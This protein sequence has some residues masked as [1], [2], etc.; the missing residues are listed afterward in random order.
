MTISQSE[1]QYIADLVLNETA[2]VLDADK[3]YLVEARLSLLVHETGQEN[4]S[5]LIAMARIPDN[6]L[7]REHIIDAMTTN[8]TSFFR[9]T[10]PFSDL[11]D[12]IM[13]DLIKARSDTR[14]INI[15]C[16]ASSSGQEPYSIAMTLHSNFKILKD[17]KLNITASDISSKVLTKARGGKYSQ[18]EI[19]RGLPKDMLSRYFTPVESDWVI[20]DELRNMIDFRKINLINPY[21]GMP[22]F[23]LI[24][25]RNVLIYF[26]EETKKLILNKLADLMKPDSLIIL[27][28]TETP[29]NI[30]DLFERYQKAHASV[31]Q[32]RTGQVD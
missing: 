10:R 17:W 12:I 4:M 7:L 32:L 1:F 16:A 20:N 23:D 11:K 14:Q 6:K 15:W 13:P 3:Q 8:E 25:I 26:N 5:A 24:F 28:G 18:I 9:D 31:Y 22:K 27:G 2:I 21:T 19:N 30:T 29:M